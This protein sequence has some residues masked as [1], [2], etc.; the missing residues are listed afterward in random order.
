MLTVAA[1]APTFSPNAVITVQGTA[2]V[3]LFASGL[4][5]ATGVPTSAGASIDVTSNIP[6]ASQGSLLVT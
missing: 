3:S 5:D 4:P 6:G 1:L 2:A